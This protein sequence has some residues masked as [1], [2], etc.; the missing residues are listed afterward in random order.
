MHAH[1]ADPTTELPDAIDTPQSLS[2]PT[3]LD[4]HAF[5]A[6]AD[7]DGVRARTTDDE[8]SAAP[9]HDTRDP[10]T[11]PS[12]EVSP[13]RTKAS[14]TSSRQTSSHRSEA[15]DT[16]DHDALIG[17]SEPMRRL[18]HLIDRAA[19]ADTTV[20]LIG[21]SGTGKELIAEALHRRS[22]RARRAYLPLNC[23]AIP[24]NLIESELFGHEKGAFTGAHQRRRGVFERAHGG[25][26]LLDEITEMS[27]D[28]QVRLLRVLETGQVTRIGGDQPID[29]D[30]RLIAATNRPP[31]EAIQAGKL[32]EDL[33]YRVSVFPIHVPPL[34]Q[35]VSDIDRFAAYFLD[36]LNA[37]FD[38]CK[39]FT[40]AALAQLRSQ[41]WPGNVRQLRNQIERAFLLADEWIDVAALA[42]PAGVATR[43]GRT[44]HV[45]VGT[46]LAE[47][48]RRVIEATLHHYDGDK[49]QSARVL[50]ISLKTLY[51]RLNSYKAQ[52]CAVG[53]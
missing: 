4:P 25:T 16:S 51:N 9:E 22:P 53:V 37:R 30:V 50:G 1:A 28:M 45:P 13:R 17:D 18:R 39:A 33:L 5:D 6:P 27:A 46:R 8:T 32:R 38:A 7:V 24:E 10:F 47:V 12:H 31:P 14:K 34:R 29:T 15:R 20:L 26:L 3:P 19:P 44:V 11:D 35:R 36:K 42:E 41:A 52:G 40:D 49:R 21:E 2:P 23:G 48:E 43:P